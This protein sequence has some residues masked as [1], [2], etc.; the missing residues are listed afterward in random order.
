[1]P[2]K[3]KRKAVKKKSVGRFQYIALG[4]LA[5]AVV[6]L[7]FFNYSFKSGDSS[8]GQAVIVKA[9]SCS[10][11]FNIR[12]LVDGL[13]KSGESF[14][15][16]REVEF[17]S[18]EGKKLVE[19]YSLSSVPALILFSKKRPNEIFDERSGAW[20]FDKSVPGID[21]KTK[22]KSG[23]VKIVE[24]RADSCSECASLERLKKTFD[25]VGISIRDYKVVEE[26]SE[27]GK[28]LINENSIEVL[29]S[30]LLSKEISDYWWLFGQLK[31]SL[32]ET[33]DYFVLASPSPPNKNIK[34]GK[35]SGLVKVKYIE[36]SKCLNCTKAKDISASIKSM[37]IYFDSET[38]IELNSDAG[39]ALVKKYNL[40]FVP[41]IILSKE[42]KDYPQFRAV[43]S[44]AGTVESDGSFILRKLDP[45]KV[46]L[47]LIR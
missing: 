46:N 35:I 29:P 26:S 31:G 27:I 22:Q 16:I 32:K 23:Q 11:C 18:E 47:E 44:T 28:K 5:I 42:I 8:I 12:G 43:L 25:E 15:K 6:L 36:D 19:K 13:L 17:N 3:K 21:V 14:S 30:I 34:T 33:K 10:D 37:G 2:K 4:V 7:V 9:S 24:I 41:T 20:V 38:S 45:S 1:M 39:K 40:T